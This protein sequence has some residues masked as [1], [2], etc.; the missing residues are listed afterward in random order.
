[1]SDEILYLTSDTN[2]VKSVRVSQYPDGMPIVD[3]MLSFRSVERVLLRPSS[4]SAFVTAMF[5]VDALVDR[6]YKA[7]ELVLPFVPGARQDH[8]NDSGDY[9]FTAKSVAKMINARRFPRVTVVDPH[10]EVTPALIER[11]ETVS[12]ADCFP[13][14]SYSAV[15]SPDAGAEKRAGAVAKKLEVPLFHAWKKRDVA[16]GKISGFGVEPLPPGI[17][18]VLVVD[19]ICDGGG[20]FL[21]LKDQLGLVQADLFV[22]HGI[23]SAGT[24]ALR[25][26]YGYILTTDS[27]IGDPRDGV[28]VIPV[29]ESLLKGEPR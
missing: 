19:D 7:P 23:F 21:G 5:W 13:K 28:T 20:T 1:M 29:C 3:R 12:A 26:R 14:A 25:S 4:F 8:L 24:A 10:S 2:E 9:L 27:I 11:C 18:R 22:T 6:G 17:G 16:T 15:I